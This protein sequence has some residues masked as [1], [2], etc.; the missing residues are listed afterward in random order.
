MIYSVRSDKSTFKNI[1]FKKGFNVVLAERTKESTKK[2]SRNGLGKS[3]LIEIIHFCLGANKGETLSKKELDGWNFTLDL[4][5][6]TKRYSVTRNTS[7]QS[8]VVIEGDCFDWP[9]KPD[10]DSKTGR[11]IMPIRNWNRSLGIL[12]FGLQGVY[13]EFKYVPTFRSLISYVMRRNGQRGAFLNPFQQYK[14]QLEWDI[15]VNNA[16]LLGLGWEYASRWQVLKDREKVLAQIKQE[17][18]AGILANIMGS[19]GEL[20]AMKVRV[21]AAAKQEEEH[22]KSFKVHP[23][24]SKIELEANELTKRIHAVVNENMNDKRLLD[25]YEASLRGEVEANPE[26]VTKVYEEAGLTLP[27]LV[28]KRL[29]DVLNFHK[30][31]V[32]NRKDFLKTEMERIKGNIALREQQKQDLSVKRAELMQVLREH[33]ALEEYTQ[34]QN[35]HQK[36]VAELK[37][38]NVRIDNLKKF[39]QGRSA[40]AVE[41]ELLRQQANTDLSER[42]SQK[43]KSILLFNSNSQALYDAPGTLSIDV[44]KTGFKYGVTIERS[45]SHGIGNMKIFCYDLMLAQIWAKSKPSPKMLIHDSIIFA[46]VDERQKA[47][48]LELAA[49][50]SEKLG[51]QYICTMNSDSIPRG[52]FNKDFDFDSFV[53]KTFTDATDDGGLLGI[54]F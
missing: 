1:E 47:L 52:D 39:E 37:D 7:D 9:I 6:G 43:E 25:H 53:R 54:R 17:A 11:Q 30:Q 49:K 3:T 51:F 35:N 34:L 10:V 23:Q 31:V 50:E 36:T 24:Y 44:S 20:E 2:D 28:T 33:G 12:M 27:D 19:I 26:T 45:G 32:V 16:F 29:D 5:I 38:L 18:Q 42:K 14:N 41:Q 21:E 15:Q 22:L 13:D 48:A 4:D 8:K 46:D 40:I